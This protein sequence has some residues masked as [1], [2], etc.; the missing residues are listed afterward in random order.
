MRRVRTL[1][2]I[3]GAAL[4]AA[5]AP[6]SAAPHTVVVPV[7]RGPVREAAPRGAVTGLSVVP[8]TG[9]AAVVIAVDS[10]VELQDFTLA[11]PHR[12]VLDLTGA[13][14]GMPARFYDKVARG[15]ITNVRVAQYRAD[16]VRVVIELDGDHKYEITRGA[17]DVRIAVDGESG[18]FAA[19]HAGAPATDRGDA[20]GSNGRGDTPTTVAQAPD[21]HPAPARMTSARADAPKTQQRSQQPRITVTYQDADVRDVL[22]A[23][24]SFSGR[25]IVVGTNVT[26][27]VSAEIRDQPWDV[28]LQAILQAQGLAAAEDSYGIITVDSYQNI[29]A[30]QATEPL[31]TQLVSINYAKSSS[32]IPT[33]ASLLS[34]D[35]G[36]GSGGRGTSTASQ[37][38][39]SCVVRG[40]VVA[41]TATNTLLITEV[42]S[43][44]NDVIAYVRDLDVRDPQVSIKAKIIFVSRTNIEQLGVAYD[45]GTAGQFHNSLVQ[46]TRPD[47]TVYDATDNVISVGGDALSAI[48]NAGRSPAA[49]ALQLV[50]STMLGKFSLTSFIDALQEIRL[51]D[52][53][54]EPSVV[55]LNNRRAEILVGQETPIRI[56]DA[57]QGGTTARATVAFKESGIILGVTPQITNN[58]QIKM[59]LHAEQSELQA[60]TSDLGY[61]FNKRRSDNQLLVNDGETAVIGG[62]TLT[63]VTS[64]RSGI[65]FLVDLPFIGRLFGQTTQQEVKQ[66]LLILITPHIID[67]GEAVGQH[68]MSGGGAR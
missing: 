43:R 30:K 3:T 35:C 56:V 7:T 19:W 28:A 31:V 50:Y 38:Q 51:S 58:R 45:L 24:A 27:T 59:E 32:L 48:A 46:R 18:K 68:N 20:G 40:A 5:A 8:N 33:I 65:P 22:A 62:L 57:G 60:A 52:T 37:A 15:G 23:F 17:N 36:G 14:L 61:T 25:T 10:A 11:S 29:L 13:T 41:D 9:R 16:V 4:G 63:Q 6:A 44:I 2:A 34:R 12:I 21:A 47:G 42:P 26:G 66:D 55:T 67:E 54:A 1:A 64:S 49:N 53:Q 39:S